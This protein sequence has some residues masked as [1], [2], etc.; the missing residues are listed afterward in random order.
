MQ[1]V[2]AESAAP[3]GEVVEFYELPQGLLLEFRTGTGV[4]AS[5]PFVDEFVEEVDREGRFIRVRL[6]DGLLET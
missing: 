6:P 2:D 3:I 1:L 5:L 4:I